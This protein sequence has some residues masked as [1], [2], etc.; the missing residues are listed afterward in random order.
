MLA[1]CGVVEGTTAL[2]AANVVREQAKAANLSFWRYIKEGPE[3]L[4]AAVFLEDLVAVGGVAVAGA[5]LG[6]SYV[7]GWL[8]V[9]FF[10]LFVCLVLL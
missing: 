10:F 5:S 4:G 9:F 3:P 7:V 8:D 1:A 2:I 6:L